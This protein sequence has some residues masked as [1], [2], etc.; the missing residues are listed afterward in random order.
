LSK[1][2]AASTESYLESARR[3][4]GYL[5]L[6]NDQRLLFNVNGTIK[7]IGY[8][9]EMDR[10]SPDSKVNYR[11]QD[12]G[13]KLPDNVEFLCDKNPWPRHQWNPRPLLCRAL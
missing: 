5:L 7:L 2:C 12:E 11:I 1:S 8:C 6:T 9:D 4:L 10:T 13:E 3:I